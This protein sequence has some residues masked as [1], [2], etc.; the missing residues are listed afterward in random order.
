LYHVFVDFSIEVFRG[1]LYNKKFK[2]K[3]SAWL[4]SPVQESTI[5]RAHR[6]IYSV[7]PA[8]EGIKAL[9]AMLDL[10]ND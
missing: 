3:R 2:S 6:I 1:A 5:I 9:E 7:L 10:E 8:P 4:S